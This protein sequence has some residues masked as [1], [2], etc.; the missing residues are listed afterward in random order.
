MRYLR[1]LVDRARNGHAVCGHLLGVLALIALVL[2]VFCMGAYAPPFPLGVDPLA[3]ARSV[4]ADL[5]RGAV[6]CSPVTP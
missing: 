4:V 2:V 1:S 3:M 5:H 6:P